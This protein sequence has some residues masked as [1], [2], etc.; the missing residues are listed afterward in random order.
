M[1]KG[2]QRTYNENDMK[3]LLIRILLAILPVIVL[4]LM[5]AFITNEF[6]SSNWRVENRGFV[7]CLGVFLGGFV[8]CIPR[9]YIN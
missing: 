6:N 7:A 9:K 1:G 8:S 2:V 3:E 5:M 4:Y